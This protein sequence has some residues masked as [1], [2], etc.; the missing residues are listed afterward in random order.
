MLLYQSID[1]FR[2]AFVFT[3]ILVQVLPF[4]IRNSRVRVPDLDEV[5]M[6]LLLRNSRLVF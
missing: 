5:P 2:F 3:L 4:M 1:D 6:K